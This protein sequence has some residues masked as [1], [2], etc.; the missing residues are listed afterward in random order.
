[1]YKTFRAG[2]RI[3]VSFDTLFDTL[4]RNHA[5]GL[6]ITPSNIYYHVLP[7]SPAGRRSIDFESRDKMRISKAI[8][9][10]LAAAT[11]VS[12]VDNAPTFE[13]RQLST[14]LS[15]LESAVESAADCAG[16]QVNNFTPSRSFLN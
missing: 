2:N 14:I 8:L 7:A 12:A 1:M 3:D 6:V 9:G 10:Y 16:C 15:E 4:R 13:K 11:A 5:A